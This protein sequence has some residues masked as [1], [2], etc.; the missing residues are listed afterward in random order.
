MN[1]ADT[2]SRIPLTRT[3]QKC[4][5]HVAEGWND[6]Q[7][8]KALVLSKSEVE[9]VLA[10]TL[11]KLGVEN[12]AAAVAKASRLGLF[13]SSITFDPYRVGDGYNRSS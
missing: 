6:E 12:R 9:S 10:I 13:G 11:N 4:L 5:A 3:E 7:I 8:G 2:T 1:H